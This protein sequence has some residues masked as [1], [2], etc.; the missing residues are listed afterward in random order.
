MLTNIQTPYNADFYS[1]IQR[2]TPLQVYYA[3][4]A[5]R[6][7]RHWRLQQREWEHVAKPWKTEANAIWRSRRADVLVSGDYL[8]R[9]SLMR[10]MLTRVCRRRYVWGER[11]RRRSRTRAAVRRVLLSDLDAVFAVGTWARAGYHEVV[12][13]HVP[14]HIFPYVCADHATPREPSGEPVVG[15]VGSLI[16]RKGLDILLNA[17][18]RM[19]DPPRLEI[20]GVGAEEAALRRLAAQLDVRVAW[21][22]HLSSAQTNEARR[23]WWLQAVPSRYDGWGVVVNESLASGVPVLASQMTGA[24]I[25]LLDGRCGDVVRSEEH[26]L[27]ALTTWLPIARNAETTAAARRVAELISARRAA[28]WLLDVLAEG[29]MHERNF[30]DEA[31]AQS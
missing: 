14:V 22:G 3:A 24:A 29:G 25:D 30:V 2:C 1:E 15:F 13:R 12:G 10:L 23:R 4:Q 7:G 28:R 27:C 5:A 31:L 19:D 6:A 17:I 26:W 11:F 16:H 9:R 18:A 8:S 20:V 21:L